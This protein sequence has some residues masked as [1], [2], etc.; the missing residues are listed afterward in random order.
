MSV[1]STAHTKIIAL[2]DYSS[3]TPLWEDVYDRHATARILTPSISVE[4]SSIVPIGSNKAIV[5]NE[6]VDNYVVRLS[7][8]VH[9]G[10]RQGPP[11]AVEAATLA[12]AVILRL[13][14][15]IDLVDGYRIFDVQGAIYDAI[16]TSSGTTGAEV[17]VDVHKVAFYEQA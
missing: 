17:I 13:R 8:R 14:T 15:H 10:Y 7:I 2:L 11:N 3:P 6:L 4:V 16:H 5:E 1:A 9:T 12:D